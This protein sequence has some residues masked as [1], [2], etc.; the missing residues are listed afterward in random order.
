[1]GELFSPIELPRVLR[2]RFARAQ[3][4]GR[5]EIEVVIRM[6]HRKRSWREKGE[7]WK[8]SKIIIFF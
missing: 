4:P 1:M 6:Q 7:K 3:R 5:Q 2:A 8:E